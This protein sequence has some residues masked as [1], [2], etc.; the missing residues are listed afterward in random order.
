MNKSN[1]N[2]ILSNR[3]CKSCGKIFMGTGKE[4][5]CERCKS[6]GAEKAKKGAG[7]LAGL[8]VVGG[9]ILSAVSKGKK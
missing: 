4:R 9:A 1:A 5:K 3:T 2:Q 7:I 8:V 6:I